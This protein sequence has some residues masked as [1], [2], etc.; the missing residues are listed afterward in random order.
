[1]RPE[2]AFALWEIYSEAGVFLAAESPAGQVAGLAVSLRK[3]GDTE[4]A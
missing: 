2:E 4:A 3:G 1:M